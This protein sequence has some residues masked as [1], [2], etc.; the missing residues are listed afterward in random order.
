M[1]K[2]PSPDSSMH[3]RKEKERKKNIKERIFHFSCVWTTSTAEYRSHFEEACEKEIGKYSG[4][5]C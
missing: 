2:I 1:A 5:T 3:L 4:G